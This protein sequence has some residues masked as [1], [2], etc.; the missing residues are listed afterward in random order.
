M[1]YKC[2]IC[3]LRITQHMKY[4]TQHMT[5]IYTTY[6]KKIDNIHEF[7]RQH[8][9]FLAQLIKFLVQHHRKI[10]A[11]VITTIAKY[12]QKWFINKNTSTLF[13][14]P[15][16]GS[17]AVSQFCRLLEDGAMTSSNHALNVLG[18]DC[19]VNESPRVKR[20]G[21]SRELQM[22]LLHCF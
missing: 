17:M 1:L 4:L 5:K 22:Q 18:S 2:H 21:Q 20:E 7:L 14:E 6:D 9:N 15:V 12:V 10:C 16:L 8:A 3:C 11:K 13:Q 19:S